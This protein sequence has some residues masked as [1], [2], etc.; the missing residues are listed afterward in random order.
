VWYMLRL[1][2]L[3]LSR[4]RASQQYREVSMFHNMKV[5]LTTTPAMSVRLVYNLTN[6]WTPQSVVFNYD[7]GTIFRMENY[8]PFCLMGC[9]NDT[10]RDAG[11]VPTLGVHRL[12]AKVF[13]QQ[14]GQGLS[15]TTSITFNVVA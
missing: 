1:P 11:F 14:N 12:I 9:T 2:K 10:G 15:T 13:S 7:N 4:D 3:R 6:E 8:E 5:S